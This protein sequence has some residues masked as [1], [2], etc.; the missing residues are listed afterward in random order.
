MNRLRGR[1]MTKIRVSKYRCLQRCRSRH[2]RSHSA[3]LRERYALACCSYCQIAMKELP[4][5]TDIFFIHPVRS[6]IKDDDTKVFIIV[7]EFGKEVGDEYL[8]CAHHLGI[9]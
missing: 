9:W 3:I 4:C 5:K 2:F 8:L 1:D 7:D 6:P